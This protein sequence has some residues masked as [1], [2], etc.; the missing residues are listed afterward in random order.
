MHYLMPVLM[1]FFSHSYLHAQQFTFK[2][3][4]L[5]IRMSPLGNSAFSDST[6]GFENAQATRILQS[7][8]GWLYM[9][10]NKGL[11]RYNGLIFNALVTESPVTAL[12]EDQHKRIWFGLKNGDIYYFDK[13]KHHKWNIEEGTPKVAITGFAEDKNGNLWLSTYGEGAYFHNGKH[14]YNINTDDGLSG[15]DIYCIAADKNG[16][17]W[18]GTDDGISIG[19]VVNGVKKI[20]KWSFNTNLPDII[21]RTLTPDEQGNMWIGT[22]DR[23]F[24]RFDAT[25]LRVERFGKDWHYGVVNA[26]HVLN[27]D[28]VL[29]GTDGE[30]LLRFSLPDGE[31]ELPLLSK[32]KIYDIGLDREANLWVLSNKNGI[33][34]ANSRIET[35]P[36]FLDNLQAV[37]THPDLGILVGTK[38]G[39][40]SKKIVGSEDNPFVKVLSQDLNIISLYTDA[41]KNIWM[42]TFGEGLYCLRKGRLPLLRFTE[43]NGLSNGSIFSI[44]GNQEHLYMATLGGMTQLDLASFEKGNSMPRMVVFNTQNGLST[45]FIYKIFIDS[46]KRIWIGTDGKGLTVGEGG[47]FRHFPMVNNISLQAVY[48]ITESV[49]KIWFSTSQNRLY[50]WYNGSFEEIQLPAG[51]KQ[52]KMTGLTTDDNGDIVIA[53]AGGIHLLNPKTRH[54]QSIRI[55]QEEKTEPNLNALAYDLQRRIWCI[56]GNEVVLYR[57]SKSPLAIDPQPIL[58]GVSV[59]M[60]SIDF[61]SVNSFNY[62]D[63]Y[64]TFDFEGLWF[65]D[66]ESVRYRYKLEGLDQSWKITRERQITYSNL[67]PGAYTFRLQASEYDN[68][69]NLQEVTYSFTIGK[70]L[71]QRWWF[72]VLSLVTAGSA[73]YFFIKTREKRLAKASSLQREMIEAQLETLKSQIN[74][75]FLFNSFNTLIATIEDNPKTAVEYVEK[76][77]DFY[78]SILQVREKNVILMVEEMQLLDNFIFLQKK[79]YGDNLMFDIDI[80]SKND[81]I[82][83][84]SLQLLAENAIKHNVVS[85]TYP[86]S[87]RISETE[88]GYWVVKNSLRPKAEKES[89]TGFGLQSLVTRYGLLTGKKVKVDKVNNEFMVMIPILKNAE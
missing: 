45:D 73:V 56:N 36:T 15:N 58:R 38:K 46:Q 86:L 79:R 39:L 33:L 23:G 32:T 52:Y 18:L 47:I 62:D 75:H 48:S 8:S 3:H 6:E 55:G 57:A 28:M 82:V 13:E 20:Q 26:I 5:S 78:R 59:F 40:F 61:Q 69:D 81:F 80:R 72:I 53:H 1:V 67:R 24:C 89:G 68:F 21:V 7:S 70:P 71:W 14:L 2:K 19:Q 44:A 42:G 85:K 4:P 34:S 17:I 22:H 31:Q 9:A 11:L 63:N 43:K 66:P 51:L 87:I 25:Q 83:P 37:C 30:G 35:I 77:S 88:N 64:L 76:L 16:Q 74:P 84:L 12:Y 27:D 50:A 29:I 54:F 60:Q 65:T 10:C 41:Y 49:G